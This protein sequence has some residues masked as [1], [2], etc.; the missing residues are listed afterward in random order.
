M[1]TPSCADTSGL[2]MSQILEANA[3]P[4]TCANAASFVGLLNDREDWF[5]S[6]EPFTHQA[7][8]EPRVSDAL[9]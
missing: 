8:Q 4:C 6:G 3:F 7:A 2:S 5:Y 1:G 9:R